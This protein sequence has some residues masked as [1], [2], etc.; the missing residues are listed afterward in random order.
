MTKYKLDG[1]MCDGTPVGLSNNPMDIVELSTVT[2]K[3]HVKDVITFL[4]HF[5]VIFAEIILRPAFNQCHCTKHFLKIN[6]TITQIAS[7]KRQGN[8]I[9]ITTNS[10]VGRKS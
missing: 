7:T 1:L 4:S 2:G 6:N 10:Y 9:Y 5:M 3:K 8:G